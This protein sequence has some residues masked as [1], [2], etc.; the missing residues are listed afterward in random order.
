M[1]TNVIRQSQRP[2]QYNTRKK[3]KKKPMNKRTPMKSINTKNL[4]RKAEAQAD[5]SNNNNFKLCH[6]YSPMKTSLEKNIYQ[7]NYSQ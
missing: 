7:L 2:S 5:N 1:N 3:A 4:N 6:A